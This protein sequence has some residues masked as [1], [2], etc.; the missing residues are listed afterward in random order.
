MPTTIEAL[1]D[2]RRLRDGLLSWLITIG[3]S[4]FA[5]VLR[6]WDLGRP[7]RIMFDE[8]YYAKDA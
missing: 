8:T 7:H 1:E 3:I 6:I 4:L 2:G 5:F